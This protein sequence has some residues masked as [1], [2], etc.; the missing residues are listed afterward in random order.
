[1]FVYRR[2]GAHFVL[3]PLASPSGSCRS[4]VFVALLF[5]SLTLMIFLK[6]QS[7]DLPKPIGSIHV[8]YVIPHTERFTLTVDVD[9]KCKDVFSYNACQIG[10]TID[11]FYIFYH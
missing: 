7:Q 2:V 10:G 8:M 11:Q 9:D 3:E 5:S 6:K 4:V 1:M